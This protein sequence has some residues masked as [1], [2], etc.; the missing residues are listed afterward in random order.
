M[1]IPYSDNYVIKNIILNYTT[2]FNSYK[3]EFQEAQNNINTAKSKLDAAEEKIN[4]LEEF[5]WGQLRKTVESMPKFVCYFCGGEVIDISPLQSLI[6][7]F[8]HIFDENRE[9]KFQIDLLEDSE[10][11]PICMSCN[12]TKV[13]KIVTTRKW[14]YV[15]TKETSIMSNN[16]RLLFSKHQRIHC[17]YGS[18]KEK[19]WIFEME[20]NEFWR[21]NGTEKDLMD[22]VGK[23]W[24]QFQAL[25]H[26]S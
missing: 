26:I 21:F 19:T 23:K 22:L 12:I 10:F 16:I 17:L 5:F 11:C 20:N 24:D 25:P 3:K 1:N 14:K 18:P 8:H 6:Q 15:L 7:R 4:E 2:H 13:D 9:I